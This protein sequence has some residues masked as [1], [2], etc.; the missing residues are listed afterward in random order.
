MDKTFNFF[1]NKHVATSNQSQHQQQHNSY[2]PK[3]NQ[4]YN[5]QI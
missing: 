5:I 1:K 4:K 2:T 3:H